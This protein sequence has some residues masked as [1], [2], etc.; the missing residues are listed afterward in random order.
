MSKAP[1]IADPQLLPIFPYNCIDTGAWY[2]IAGARTAGFRPINAKIVELDVSHEHSKVVTKA[3][4]GAYTD[5]ERRWKE[6]ARISH[7]LMD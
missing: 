7:I 4:N 3:I 5:E 6:T 2:W 1:A